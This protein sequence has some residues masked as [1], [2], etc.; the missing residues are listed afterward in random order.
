MLERYSES[1][2]RLMGTPPEEVGESDNGAE[3]APTGT[4]GA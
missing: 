2:E 1:D 4:D 3:R